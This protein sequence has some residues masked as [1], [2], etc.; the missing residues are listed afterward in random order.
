[1]T[2]LVPC[3]FSF[4]FRAAFQSESAATEPCYIHSNLQV[5][6]FLRIRS[7]KPSALAPE[8]VQ[9]RK[10][11]LPTPSPESPSRRC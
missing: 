10:F 9:E 7:P 6:S 2:E 8:A 11:Y 5:Y 1:M 4:T 3:C